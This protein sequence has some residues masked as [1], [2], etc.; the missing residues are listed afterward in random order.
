M[1]ILHIIPSVAQVRGGPSQAVLEMVKALRECDIDAEIATTNDNGSALLNVPLNQ[2]V[3]YE[4]VPVW[5]F[6]RFSPKIDSL[7]E[8]AFSLQL[9]NWLWQNIA[10]YDILH[11]HAIFSY[12]S[13]AAMA[14][15]RIQR[16]PYIAEPHG[17]LCQWSLQQS[18]QKKKNYL[19][20]IERANLNQSLSL[21]FSS[22][23]EQQEASK[24]KLTSPGFILPHGLSIPNTTPNA[25]KQLRELLQVPA[26]RP[27]ILFM[28]RLHPKKGLDYLIPALGKLSHQQFSFVLAGSG[29]PEYDKEIGNLLITAGIRDRTYIAGFVTDES[30]DILLQGADLFALTSYS[31]NFGIAVLEAMAVGLPV[32]LTPGVALAS[33]VKEEQLGYV[34]EL[35]VEEI[36][37]T[38]EYALNHQWQTK[39]MGDRACQLILDNYCW[40]HIGSKLSQ[41]YSN[42]LKQSS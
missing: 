35:N 23:Q 22:L 30:K 34:A 13:T 5:F 7:R 29:T 31:E 11:V 24:V 27:V 14:I 32:I 10:K 4:E 25:R 8:F 17:L 12:A 38:I 33:M 2:K 9:T 36:A 28:S 37:A 1:K 39:Q 40:H 16:I 3:N 6:P 19:S 41:I 20:L 42:I 26:D 15:A 18:A 21:R